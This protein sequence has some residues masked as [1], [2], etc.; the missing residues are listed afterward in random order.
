MYEK[1]SCEPY[2]GGATK[3]GPPPPDGGHAH[4]MGQ[5]QTI[6]IFLCISVMTKPTRENMDKKSG[7]E[8]GAGFGDTPRVKSNFPPREISFSKIYWK[9]FKSL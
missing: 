8:E 7:T 2:S 9:K 3:P 4:K 1:V 5:V 6:H